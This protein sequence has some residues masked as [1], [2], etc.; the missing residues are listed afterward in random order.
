MTWRWFNSFFIGAAL[1]LASCSAR[2]NPGGLQGQEL[3]LASGH[4]LGQTFVAHYAGLNGISVFLAPGESSEGQLRLHLRSEAQSTVDLTTTVLPLSQITRPTFYPFFFNAFADSNQ[5]YYYGFLEVEGSGT[6]QIGTASGETYLDGALYQDHQPLDSQMMFELR[7]AS[8]QKWV[9]LASTAL[10][11]LTILALAALVYLVPGWALLVL[12]WPE[13]RLTWPEQLGLASGIS[14]AFYPL[15]FLWTD[16]VGLHLGPGYAWLPV[17]LGLLI[18]GWR[19]RLWQLANLWHRGQVWWSSQARLPDLVFIGISLLIFLARFSVIYS[20]VAPPWGDSYQ[21]ALMAQLMKDNQGLF[22]SWLPYTPYSSLTIQFGFS[23]LVSVFSWLSGIGSLLSTLLV[24][25]LI[26]GLAILGLYPLAVRLAQGNR[27][28]GVG[29][30]LAAGLLSPMP[31]YY[32]NWGRYAQLAGQAILPVALWFLCETLDHSEALGRKVLLSGGLLAGMVL[33]YYRMPFYYAAFVFAWLLGWGI[34]DRHLKLAGWWQVF[35]RLSLVAGSAALLFLP[36][37][38]HLQGGTLATAV[39]T[40]VATGASLNTVLATYSQWPNIAFYIPWSLI[41]LTLLG[42]I[43]SL[44]RR[45]WKVVAI[46]FWSIGLAGLT[47]TRLLRLPGANFLQNFAVL[48]A[49][50]I[51]IAFLVGWLVSQVA[52]GLKERQSILGVCLIG[53]AFWATWNQWQVVSAEQSLAVMVTEPDQRAATWIREHL[54]VDIRFLVEGNR[55]YNGQSVVGT[56]AGWWLPLLANRENTIPPQY[57][58][59]NEK[60]S[61]PEYTRQVVKLLAELETT[62]PASPQGIN[63][64]C[65]QGITHVYIGQRQGRVGY[66]AAQLFSPQSL[67][68]SADFD[69]IYHQDRVWIFKLEPQACKAPL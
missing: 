1:L 36:W 58:I 57:A 41:I 34:L 12:F 62:S 31:A 23:S 35:L 30:V 26:N 48:V 19:G 13:N 5:H 20:L 37:V 65:A 54:P 10:R 49:L 69:L 29:A 32:L 51:P 64:L 17:G 44:V 4:T 63:L 42:S 39:E 52:L 33:T 3:L 38:R 46:G 43:Y 67:L 45:S 14:L 21:H 50:Y 55:I 9:G 22:N 25:Q 16:L 11:W 59:L 28:A 56:D 68:N 2:P 53:I 7:Y 60:P 15:L 47:A 8:G 66:A 24:G 27:W 18:L 40:G 61:P 6:V